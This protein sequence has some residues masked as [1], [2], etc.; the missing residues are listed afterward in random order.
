MIKYVWVKT[1][2]LNAIPVRGLRPAM[3]NENIFCLFTIQAKLFC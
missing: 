1:G 2:L 3:P